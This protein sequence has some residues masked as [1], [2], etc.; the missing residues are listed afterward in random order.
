STVRRERTLAQVQVDVPPPLMQLDGW[1]LRLHNSVPSLRTFVVAWKRQPCPYCDALLLEGEDKNWCCKG[2]KQLLDRLP[3]LP[4]S[5][6]H[7]IRDHPSIAS[8]F[9]RKVNNLFAFS[10]LGV[11]G[12]F[13]PLPAPSNVV[14]T[15]RVYHQLRTIE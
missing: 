8:N 11:E 10:S 9:S 5:L 6:E 1:W 15:G 14:I 3:P 12:R 4:S 7:Y 13:E 2:G